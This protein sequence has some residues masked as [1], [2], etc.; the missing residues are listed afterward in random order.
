MN[1]SPDGT[2]D[3]SPAPTPA[4]GPS[5]RI[6]AWG[7]HLYTALGLACAARMAILIAVGGRLDLTHAFL[8]M[9]AACFID[10]TDGFLAR[11]VGVKE[12]L[13]GFDGRKLDDIVDFQ[14]YT[15][16]PLLLLWRAHVLPA[17][18]E[19]WLLFP[20]LASAYGFCQSEAKTGDGYF[21]GFPSYWNV[22]AFYLVELQI[23]P[24]PALALIILF[25]TL[26]FVPTKYLYPSQGGPFSALMLTGG[27]VYIVLMLAILLGWQWNRQ[28]MIWLS[29][30]YPLSYLAASWIVTIS[31]SRPV[32]R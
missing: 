29:L 22:V 27:A 10:G 11:R 15:S 31:G 32:R 4:F 23:G 21:L 30:S 8:W 3:G 18:Y 5:R 24:W 14:T 7:V 1:A 20:L 9:L 12:V 28:A 19:G 13:P 16:L 2:P 25:A 26:T 17:G 6:A